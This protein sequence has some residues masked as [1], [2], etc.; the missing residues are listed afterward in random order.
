MPAEDSSAGPSRRKRRSEWRLNRL[1]PTGN[2][3]VGFFAQEQRHGW[4][5]EMLGVTMSNPRIEQ[6]ILSIARPTWQKVAM[7]ILKAAEIEGVD[8]PE[9][10]KGYEL[11]ASCIEAL[12]QEGRLAAQGDLKRWRHSEVRLP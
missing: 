4:S 10:E 2:S 3:R 7:V 1:D 5:A 11:I 8:V 12:V 6:A 9:G